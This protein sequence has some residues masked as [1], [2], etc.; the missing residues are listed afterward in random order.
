MMS[1]PSP[2]S[3]LPI[4]ICRGEHEAENDFR[5]RR[6]GEIAAL[7]RYAGIYL[8]PRM[9]KR[10]YTQYSAV[11][12]IYRWAE[13]TRTQQDH[14]TPL[15]LKSSTDVNWVVDPF[16]DDIEF[17][18][19]TEHRTSIKRRHFDQEVATKFTPL[20]HV[21]VR[22]RSKQQTIARD[23][24]QYLLANV[25]ER[26]KYTKDLLAFLLGRNNMT[27]R[28]HHFFEVFRNAGG[29]Y[30]ARYKALEIAV[31][32]NSPTV[33]AVLRHLLLAPCLSNHDEDRVEEE[34]RSV[35]AGSSSSSSAA[36]EVEGDEVEDKI[37]MYHCIEEVDDES[38]SSSQEEKVDA[39]VMRPR[40]AIVTK[41][42]SRRINIT[43]SFDDRQQQQQGTS[44]LRFW[45]R[46]RANL[47]GCLAKT[48]KPSQ[49]SSPFSSIEKW[50]MVE[51]VFDP[52]MRYYDQSVK[53]VPAETVDRI[54]S[55][56][57]LLTRCLGPITLGN[58]AHRVNLISTIL[59][60]ITD[61]CNDGG[62]K[63]DNACRLRIL[64]EGGLTGVRVHAHG[65][66]DYV[67]KR[68]KKPICIVE[69][70][71]VDLEKGLAQ[72]LV[73]MEVAAD[74]YEL[75][76]VYGIVTNYIQWIFLVSCDKSIKQNPETISFEPGEATANKVSVERIAGKVY[77][78]FSSY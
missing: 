2:S 40:T 60:Y 66:A 4:L 56:L 44:S 76:K 73:E 24:A 27:E 22:D 58:E 46:R 12:I 28:I 30:D 33:E 48:R 1:S 16:F 72:A 6:E 19:A 49:S 69:A 65:R 17:I 62:A 42:K 26:G 10:L 23:A 3:P 68:G 7:S 59:A 78:M 63:E 51:D 32:K 77:S 36:A 15:H 52:I 18:L 45:S 20:L 75:D 5:L 53:K 50:V 31:R 13:I 67:I 34:Q 21:G 41:K 38:D 54:Y 64:M 11:Q 71:K 43:A 70:K 29:P 8:A 35:I 74:I 14:G 9:I 37:I 39:A 47:N 25:S 57:A 61:I 55:H